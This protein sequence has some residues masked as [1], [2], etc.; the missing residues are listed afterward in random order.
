MPLVDLLWLL[1]HH[2]INSVKK[3]NV[4]GSGQKCTKHELV[5]FISQLSWVAQS[6]NT[7]HNVLNV[8]FTWFQIAQFCW[9]F[10]QT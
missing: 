9:Q 1:V 8:Y 6:H 2:Q 10:R 5:L 3:Q 4:E 7:Y